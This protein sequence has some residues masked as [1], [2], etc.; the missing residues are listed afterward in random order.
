MDATTTLQQGLACLPV[1]RRAILLALKQSGE[2]RAEEIASQVGITVSA[3]R[4][5]LAGLLANKLVS[6]REAKGEPGRPKHFYFLATAGEALFPK[7][8]SELLAEL[9]GYLEEASPALV[10]QAF[11]R[12]RQRRVEAALGRLDGRPFAE[13]V[14]ELARILDEEGYLAEFEVLPSGGFRLTQHNCPV[15]EVAQRF[16]LACQSEVRF[17][18]AALPDAEIR[19][20]ATILAGKHV[21]SYIVCQRPGA[22]GC[23]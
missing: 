22:S 19:Q 14:A 8:Y 9:L 20:T 18:S 12:R 3:V 6:Y 7:S 17:L 11:E 21:C 15:L 16:R 23:H 5:H 10:I 2:A 13:R 1:T 4:Q